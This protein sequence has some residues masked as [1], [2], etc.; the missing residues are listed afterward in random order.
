MI[1]RLT[2]PVLLIILALLGTGSVLRAAEYQWSVSVAN[3]S[4]Q[5]L[6]FHGEPAGSLDHGYPRAFLWIPPD[7]KRVRGVIL[8]QNNMEEESILENANLRKTMSDLGF[9]EIWITP[10]SD[11]FT[12]GS[13]K[14]PA[15]SSIKR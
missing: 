4:D 7:C 14:A 8:S 2:R 11:Q 9:A 3:V 5:S 12:F 10:T 15:R 13:T 6:T 1:S